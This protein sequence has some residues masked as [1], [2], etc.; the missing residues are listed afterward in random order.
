MI[1]EK[2]RRS[3][4]RIVEKIRLIPAGEIKAEDMVEM[5]LH[6]SRRRN[7]DNTV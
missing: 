3:R 5:R 2:C 1:M 6:L 4:R 7:R